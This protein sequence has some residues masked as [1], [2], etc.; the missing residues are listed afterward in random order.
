MTIAGLGE[1]VLGTLLLRLLVAGAPKEC[2]DDVDPLCSGAS[3]LAAAVGTALAGALAIGLLS[4]TVQRDLAR[5]PEIATG[6]R[7]QLNLEEM[8]FVSNDLLRKRLEGTMATPE[9]VS[10]AVRINTEA[11]L[12]ALKASFFALAAFAMFAFVPNV[13]IRAESGVGSDRAADVGRP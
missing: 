7:A 12:R 6:L 5:N 8:S 4:V 1:G 2:L 9:L 11:R 10:E 13:R 3:H